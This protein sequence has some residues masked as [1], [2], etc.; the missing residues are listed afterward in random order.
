MNRGSGVKWWRSRLRV[1]AGEWGGKQG[2]LWSRAS[3]I[4]RRCGTAVS[5]S[6]RRAVCL[7]D[8][9]ECGNFARVGMKDERRTNQLIENE[10][11]H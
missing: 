8:S 11:S 3:Q 1:I 6:V 5:L 9:A 2:G 10:V 4:V 7:T